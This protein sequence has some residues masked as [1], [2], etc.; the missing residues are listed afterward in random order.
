MKKKTSKKS[1]VKRRR[2]N[3]GSV[4]MIAVICLVI[5]LIVSLFIPISYSKNEKVVTN[6]KT[7]Y[8]SEDAIELGTQDTFS[9]GKNGIK[10]VDYKYN[11]TLFEFIFQRDKAKKTELSSRTETEVEDKIVLKGTRKWQYMMCS[12][13]TYRYYTDEEFK[14][15]D[16]GFTSKSPDY[17]AEN[18]QGNKLNL[19]DSPKGNTNSTRPTYV[20]ANCTIVDVPYQTNYMDVSWLYIGETQNGFGGVNGWKYICSNSSLNY[21]IS[22]IDKTIYR[23]TKQRTTTPNYT[24]PAPTSPTKDYNAKYKCDSE[25]SSAMAKINA[26]GA[27]SSSAADQVKVLY[28]QCLARAGF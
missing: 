25:Y 26:A 28:G 7:T 2:L 14:Q 18:K 6:Y 17:C 11:L 5:G 1:L 20:P 12:N 10:Y 21:T 16:V 15:P 9:E 19:A 22:A 27:G 4:V 3:I 13:G 23:G 8:K 24:T